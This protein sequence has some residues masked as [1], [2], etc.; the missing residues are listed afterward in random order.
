MLILS[1]QLIY[2]TFS[3]KY[4]NLGNFHGYII[5]NTWLPDKSEKDKTENKED[6]DKSEKDKTESSEDQPKTHDAGEL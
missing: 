6:T 3:G 2:K 5:L 4:V 1:K